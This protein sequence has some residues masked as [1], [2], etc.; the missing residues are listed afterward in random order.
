MSDAEF[1][2]ANDP[3]AAFSA[4]G[5]ETRMAI[6]RALCDPDNLVGDS[7]PALTFWNSGKPWACGIPASTTT[8]ST[9]SAASSAARRS[10]ATR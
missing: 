3:E 5:D 6:L 8:T 4:L 2:E 9:T 10:G 7:W 1:V